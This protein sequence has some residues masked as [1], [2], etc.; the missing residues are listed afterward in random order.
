MMFDKLLRLAACAPAVLAMLTY[1]RVRS[2]CCA[3]A[4]RNPPSLATLLE[5]SLRTTDEW[6]C[7]QLPRRD[8]FPDGPPALLSS[9][10]ATWLRRGLWS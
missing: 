4:S 3:P 2:A 7:Y 9:P 1:W 10:G 8:W 6:P 5:H